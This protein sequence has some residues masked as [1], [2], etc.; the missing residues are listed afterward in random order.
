MKQA[1]SVSV[2]WTSIF[3]SLIKG[4]VSLLAMAA[5][6]A[7]ADLITFCTTAA[8]KGME[9]V[10]NAQ[11]PAYLNSQFANAQTSV[12]SGQLSVQQATENLTAS[13]AALA[14]APPAPVASNTDLAPLGAA[15]QL[16][17]AA[18]LLRISRIV[19]GEIKL[20][21]SA[22]KRALLLSPADLGLMLS[23]PVD[24]QTVHATLKGYS[25]QAPHHCL[26]PEKAIAPLVAVEA[27]MGIV[28]TGISAFQPTLLS[29]GK[30]SG[31]QDGSMLVGAGL[32][33]VLGE[34]LLIH[35]PTVTLNN[36]IIVDVKSLRQELS[37]LNQRMAKCTGD[38]AKVA[39][40]FAAD[41]NGYLTAIAKSDGAHPSLM[42]LAA[43]RAALD[44]GNVTLLLVFQRDVSS[45]GMAAIKPNWFQQA[46]LESA[47][48]EGITYQL[49]DL[50]GAIKAAGFVYDTY[51]DTCELG[52]WQR[53]FKGC[54][55][56]AAIDG[57]MKPVDTGS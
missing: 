24:A 53:S 30:V 23:S 38:P 42:D 34:L 40:A 22:Q 10:W 47:Y 37:K 28:A 46:R 5:I 54:A 44:A 1:D 50:S 36:Q 15:S 49:T 3:G 31:V 4:L 32:H 12:V 7:H 17:D 43:R 39:A 52:D 57:L 11:C 48:A 8:P 14:K 19:G 45:G 35:P 2:S 6:P 41:A 33:S 16:R 18:S 51:T 55:S 21:L 27:V 26:S 25:D 56:K 20:L 13:Y 29:T 9:D